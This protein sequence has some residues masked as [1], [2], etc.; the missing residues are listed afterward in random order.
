MI[1]ELPRK[2]LR[3]GGLKFREVQRV[4]ELD[5]GATKFPTKVREAVATVSSDEIDVVNQKMA[6]VVPVKDEAT[7]LLE[8]VL[9]GIPHDCQVIVVSNSGRSPVNR[10][11]MELETIREFNH[12]VN[13]RITLVHQKDPGIAEAFKTLGYESVLE[14]GLVRDGKAEGMFVAMALAKMMGKEY[15]GFIDADNFIPGAVHE[16]VEIFAAGFTLSES[17][18]SMIRVSW[19]NK[20]KIEEDQMIFPKWGRVSEVTNACINKLIESHTSFGT[21]IV[22]TGNA[23]EH[24]ISM[25]LAD[26]LPFESGFALETYELVS[27]MEQFGGLIPSLHPDVVSKG[28]DVFQIE[29]RNPHLHADKGDA[30]IE[31]MLTSSLKAIYGSP[32]CTDKVKTVILEALNSAGVNPEGLGPP[33]PPKTKPLSGLDIKRF[34]RSLRAKAQTLTEFGR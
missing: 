1:L 23:G 20:P 33:Y 27:I 3:L 22:R 13:D 31:E 34:E 7:N 14:D 26:L 21:D 11:Q 9:S 25:A 29:T 30:H 19:A 10:F 4:Y 5:S 17:P 32:I 16:Y 15:V 18:Y 24:A 8:G 28:V 12:F 2:T 6:V